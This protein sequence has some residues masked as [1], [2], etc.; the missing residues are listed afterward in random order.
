VHNQVDK[1][2][3]RALICDGERQSRGN[4]SPHAF[5]HVHLGSLSKF[6]VHSNE[7]IRWTDVGSR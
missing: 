4:S 7:S 3:V 6:L 1:N 2:L 5:M